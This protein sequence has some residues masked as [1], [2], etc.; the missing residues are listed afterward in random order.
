[1]LTRC[2]AEFNF[3]EFLVSRELTQLCQHYH[4]VGQFGRELSQRFDMMAWALRRIAWLGCKTLPVATTRSICLGRE[5][6]E[7]LAQFS[8]WNR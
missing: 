4:T 1:M 2:L 6:E 5:P 8:G 3:L 7:Y